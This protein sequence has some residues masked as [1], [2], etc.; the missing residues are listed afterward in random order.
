MASYIPDDKDLP[1]QPLPG[2]LSPDSIDVCSELATILSRIHYPQATVTAGAESNTNNN[3]SS[4]P[5]LSTKD[6]PGALDTLKR[7]VQQA[8]AAV[9]TLP[10]ID[11]TVAE[12]EA[13]MRAM[14]ERIEKQQAALRQ[15]KEFGLQFAAE[16]TTAAAAT[17]GG[18]DVQM[19][20]TSAVG[21]S[22]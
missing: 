7:K 21:S 18:G 4:Q 20:G 13:E 22:G 17:A 9:H 1:P 15:L 10:D 19:G 3:S 8:R 11:R 2:N 6:L 12:Q 14:Q 16:S 5:P